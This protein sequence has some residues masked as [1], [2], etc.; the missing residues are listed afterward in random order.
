MKSNLELLI[1]D[2][3]ERVRRES[4]SDEFA[5]FYIGREWEAHIVNPTNCV[6]LGEVPGEYIGTGLS[7]EEAV[8]NLQ[9]Q[10]KINLKGNT[11]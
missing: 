9:E 4:K 6:M 1:N 3:L 8:I 5:L 10:L 11:K 7:P 2:C